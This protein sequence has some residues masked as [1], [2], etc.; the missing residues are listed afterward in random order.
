MGGAGGWYSGRVAELSSSGAA[1]AGAPDAGE[2][3]VGEPDT[4][5]S[6]VGYSGGGGYPLDGGGEYEP[7][8]GAPNR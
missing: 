6:Y 4:G 2:P 5:D 3:D 8:P 1:C 7:A